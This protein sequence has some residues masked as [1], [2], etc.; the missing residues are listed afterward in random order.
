MFEIE[1]SFYTTTETQPI[2]IGALGEEFDRRQLIA[3]V[4]QSVFWLGQFQCLFDIIY[5]K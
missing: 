5:S 4:L 2:S 1:S 3:N